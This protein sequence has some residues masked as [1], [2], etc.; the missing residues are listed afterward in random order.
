LKPEEEATVLDALT[1]CT[2]QGFPWTHERLRDI[3]NNII[4]TCDPSFEGVGHN[5]TRQFLLCKHNILQTSWMPKLETVCGQAV[6]PTTHAAWME[7]LGNTIR[8]HNITKKLIYSSDKVGFNP[9]LSGCACAIGICGAGGVYQQQAGKRETITAIAT[10]CADGTLLPPAVIFKDKD[11]RY[12]GTRTTPC[13]HCKIGYSKKG[14]INGEVGKAWIQQFDEFT[15]EKANRHARLLLVDGHNSHYTEGF[16]AH[17]RQ[18]NI[19]VLCYPTHSTH[20]YQGLNVVV[21]A[22]LENTTTHRAR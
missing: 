7:L 5:W 17:A 16:I 19:H 21:F 4:H 22:Q 11:I 14:W 18:T 1:E 2:C 8:E 6:N 13:T 9:A 12:H 20:V 3:V 10:I 15:K